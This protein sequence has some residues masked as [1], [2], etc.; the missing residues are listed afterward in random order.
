MTTTKKRKN[1]RQGK[2]RRVSVEIPPI[3]ESHSTKKLRK[4]NKRIVESIKDKR[5][6]IFH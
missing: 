4:K 3:P 1:L 5:I 2:T 6:K